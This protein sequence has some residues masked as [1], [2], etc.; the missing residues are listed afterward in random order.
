[1]SQ[2]L[3]DPVT[4]ICAVDFHDTTG[5]HTVKV[6]L[7]DLD[8]RPLDVLAMS[9]ASDT[10][11]K[12]ELERRIVYA[13]SLPAG[14]TKVEI[15]F[16]PASLPPGTVSFPDVFFLA[17]S[18]RALVNSARALTPQDLTVPETD[19]TKAG[20]AV[21][22]A[23]LRAR[24]TF[25][26]S[27]LQNDL[28]ALTTAAAGLPGAPGPVR[29]ALMRCSFYG[30]AG[31]VPHSSNGIDAGLA[32]QAASVTK[33][34]Q[35]RVNK[36]A[37][38]VFATAPA[39]DL[40]ALLGTI[41]GNGFVVLPR[42]TPPDFASLQDAFAQS[43]A[44]VASDP[45]APARWIA[46]LSH[47]RPGI[48]RLDAAGTVAQLL[49][50]SVADPSALLL[51]QLPAIASD[52]WLGLGI[53]PASPPAKGRVAFACLALGDPLTHNS[54]AGL[55]VDEWPER[56]PSVQENAAVAF[57]YEEPKARA[58]QALL[59]AVCPDGRQTWD[60]DLI[61]GI[62]Q[63]TLE[64]TRIRAV[65]LDSVQ[66][67]GQILPALYFAFNVQGATISANFANIREVARVTANVR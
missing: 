31:A 51:G 65:D 10:P 20:G 39:S 12:G 36:A 54:Y 5:D 13:A 26:V 53:D 23:D 35:D 50:A 57:H 15:D 44:L 16:A 27:S 29:D 22:L 56:I 9:D 66:E 14:A 62:L 37:A 18:L 8:V 11:Q 60:D 21:D 33:I 6:S 4:V 7:R 52:K 38:V 48:S 58:P 46:Q 2:W 42:F 30:V 32:D 24:A 1:L 41:F 3:P 34:L 17:K 19:A 47:I 40:V 64:L 25:A 45:Q 55:L 59:L 49:G 28:L 63:E 67:V 43:A 61:T